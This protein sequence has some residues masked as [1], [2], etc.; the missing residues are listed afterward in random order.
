MMILRGPSFLLL[1]LLCGTATGLVHN[2]PR[3]IGRHSLHVSAVTEDD[4]ENEDV[5]IYSDD[6]EEDDDEE[7]NAPWRKNARWNSLSPKLKLRIIQEAQDR[8]V[9]NKKS[10]EPADD[11]K[12]R[13]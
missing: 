6:R 9:A 4:M 12:R 3:L 1:A 7:R 5:L 13:K 10:R 2:H 8:A 11:K